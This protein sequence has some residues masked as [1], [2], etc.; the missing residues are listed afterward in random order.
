[1]PSNGGLSHYL[2]FLTI[3]SKLTQGA[4][5]T[6]IESR[7]VIDKEERLLVGL[8]EDQRF[9]SSGRYQHRLGESPP[10]WSP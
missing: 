2:H 8:A 4:Y 7:Q 10:D 5:L 3:Y 6:D 9:V 1:M